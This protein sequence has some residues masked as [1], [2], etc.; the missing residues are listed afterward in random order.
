MLGVEKSDLEAKVRKA[1]PKEDMAALQKQ[2]FY[3]DKYTDDEF[4]YR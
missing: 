3:S 4:E 1:I 2:I